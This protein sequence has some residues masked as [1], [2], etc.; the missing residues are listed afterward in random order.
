MGQWGGGGVGVARPSRDFT[1]LN[2]FKLHS[3]AKI[4]G[5]N[6]FS[7]MQQRDLQKKGCSCKRLGK[8]L[9]W[10]LIFTFTYVN[11]IYITHLS[12]VKV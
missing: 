5:H 3:S 11:A 1:G 9:I 12:A 8:L 10:M 6:F 2:N 4:G 7:T